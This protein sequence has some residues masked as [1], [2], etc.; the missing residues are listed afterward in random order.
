MAR[1]NYI[2]E[3]ESFRDWAEANAISGSER[4]LWQ[5]LFHQCNARAFKDEWPDG[6]IEIRNRELVAACGFSRVTV[7]RARERLARRGI[8][9]FI[10]GGGD[11][12]C[13][14]KLHYLSLYGAPVPV[15]KCETAVDNRV[16]NEQGYVQIEH[17][18]VQIETGCVQNEQGSVQ[19]E[20]GREYVLHNDREINPTV[21][22]INEKE[23]EDLFSNYVEDAPAR[24]T[25]YKDSIDEAYR[26]EIG[27]AATKAE[28]REIG[29]IAGWNRA[30]GSLVREAIRRGASANYPA[31]Y[32]V[33]CLMSWG[34]VGLRTADELDTYERYIDIT[35]T[36][37]P[38]IAEKGR[39][40]L[41]AF[42]REIRIKH[43]MVAV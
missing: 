10:P 34:D 6:F 20:Q 42:L 1:V 38:D 33:K 21:N 36:P 11:A 19:N 30:D 3:M 25:I 31:R 37:R 13:T 15:E 7:W 29:E 43:R 2:K 22:D 5:A 16:Q 39:E 35:N 24:D 26:A 9:D 4:L 18:G 32:A 17:E 27:R 8:I 23:E 12:H 28:E 40:K 41:E 14:Y